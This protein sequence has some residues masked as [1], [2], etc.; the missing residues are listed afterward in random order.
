MRALSEISKLP[1]SRFFTQS[2]LPK[3]RWLTMY[4]RRALAGQGREV[5]SALNNFD[6]TGSIPI[7]NHPRGGSG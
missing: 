5:G 2:H 4:Q 7:A 3:R 1:C 6:R